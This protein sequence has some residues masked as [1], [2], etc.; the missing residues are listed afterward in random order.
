M[1]Y[2][3]ILVAYFSCSGKTKAAAERLAAITGADLYEIT[4]EQP[5]TRAD[6]DWHDPQSRSSLEM[7]NPA[8]RPAI[9][10]RNPNLDRYD[11]VFVGFP[12]WWYIAPYDHQYLFGT[13]RLHREDRH[14]V[15]DLGQQRH[16]A[17]RT[18]SPKC[19]SDTPLE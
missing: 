17:L 7:R 14:P 10:D 1:N 4:P 5:Y 3:K 11:V 9:I 19:L 6:L 13:I 12:V 18:E 15:C 2:K 8:S 16:R